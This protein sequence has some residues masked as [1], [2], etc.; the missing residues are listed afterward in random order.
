MGYL[1]AQQ[2]T[3]DWRDEQWVIG[4][5][6]YVNMLVYSYLRILGRHETAG[7]LSKEMKRFTI[8]GGVIHHHVTKAYRSVNGIKRYYAFWSYA[9]CI[10][11]NVS[12]CWATA[13]QFFPG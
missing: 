9:R 10:A 3:S 13:W 5:G 7:L 6:L 2:P 11:A 4:Y 12:T 1:V 8:T